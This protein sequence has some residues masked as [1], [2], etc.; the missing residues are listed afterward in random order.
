M[1][2]GQNSGNK[3]DGFPGLKMKAYLVAEKKR[4]GNFENEYAPFYLWEN[5]DGINQF[6]LKDPFSN[7]LNSF[8]RPAIYNWYSFSDYLH[9][10]VT[11]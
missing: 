7:I 6:I 4:Y 9:I 11:G 2:K 5:E 1:Y 8:G 3:T 10:I